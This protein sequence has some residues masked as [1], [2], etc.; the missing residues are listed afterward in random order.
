[1]PDS[2]VRI[3]C[4]NLM[5]RKVLA[6]PESARG[7]IVRCKGCSTSIRIPGQAPAAA[8]PDPKKGKKKGKAA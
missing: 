2:S 3:R 6:V 5:C 1:M 8:A 7:H 4:P